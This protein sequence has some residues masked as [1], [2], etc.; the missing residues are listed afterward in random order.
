MARRPATPLEDRPKPKRMGAI[1]GLAPFITPYRRL[2]LATSAALVL[3]AMVTL[4]LPVAARRVVDGFQQGGEL[5]DSYFLAAHVIAA[6]LAVGTGLRYWLVTRFGERVVADIRK[7]VFGR[8][9]ELSPAFYERVLTGEIISRITTDTTLILSLLGSSISVAARNILILIGGITMLLFTSAK[10]TGLVLLIVPLVIIP[11]VV[12]GRRLR[13]LSRENQDW[14]A[15][16]SGSASEALSSVQ[17]V[18]AFTHEALTRNAFSEVTEKAFAS[19]NA[20]ITTRAIMTMIV[21]FLVFAGIVGVLWIGARDVREGLMTVGQL[22]QFV[23]YAVMVSAAVGALTEI[24]GEV[25]RAAGATE[26]LVELLHA[27]DTVTDPAKPV[28]LPSPVKGAIAFENVTFHYPSRP[29]TSA[30]NAV[31]LRVAPGETVALVGPSG[32]GKSTL[33]H[34]VAGF[35]V[36][37]VGADHPGLCAPR[38]GVSGTAAH[39]LG[40]C[41]GKHRLCGAAGGAGQ[42][43]GAASGPGRRRA[44]AFRRRGSGQVPGRTLGRHAP[45]HRHRPRAGGKARFPLFRRALHRAPSPSRPRSSTKCALSAPSRAPP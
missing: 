31:S 40:R 2:A 10:L 44:G 24:W 20:R 16:S 39:A 8:V 33:V 27:G 25:Q 5:L 36:P 29:E 19:A 21:I 22:V 14:I 45:A 41:A 35:F 38:D 26:R 6:L 28:P 17:T 12:M 11:I 15:S 23:I 13:K 3:T 30:L 1:R 32:C 9:I 34:L 7:A 37:A 42:G 43:A 4:I 18:Q